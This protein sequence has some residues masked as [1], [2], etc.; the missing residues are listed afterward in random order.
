MQ[1][2]HWEDGIPDHVKHVLKFL[3]KRAKI[4]DLGCGSGRDSIFLAERGFDV[5]G[6]DLSKEAIR[7]AITNSQTRNI[8]FL[9]GDA[10]CLPFSHSFFDFVYSRYV[11]EHAPLNAVSSEVFRVL[12][13]K[14]MALLSFILNMKMIMTQDFREFLKKD[15]ILSA[16]GNFQILTC[17][18][19][20]IFDFVGEKSHSHDCLLVTLK[21]S[22]GQSSSRFMNL[23]KSAL[24]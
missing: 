10:E 3:R 6:V 20:R 8:C 4:L 15:D 17:R 22:K 19:F 23:S 7:R 18:E 2:A 5:W 24:S 13:K 11:F 12:K 16:F 21:K 9:V 14:G 1:R